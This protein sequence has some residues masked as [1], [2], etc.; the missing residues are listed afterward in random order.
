LAGP[1]P[2]KLTREQ[3]IGLVFFCTLI[4]AVAQ[5]FFKL[6]AQNLPQ[7]GPIAIAANPMVVLRNLPL[8]TGLALYGVFMLLFVIALKDAELSIIY[9]VISF[10]Y[11]WVALLSL[12]FF[13]ERLNPMKV[14]GIGAIVFG[15]MVLGKDGRR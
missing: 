15:V 2:R 7:I 4:S 9:P 3:S 13:G 12:F 1:L 6:G 8:L 11:V 10:A 14:A 5:I